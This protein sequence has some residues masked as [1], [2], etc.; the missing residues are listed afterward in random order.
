MG[1]REQQ[2]KGTEIKVLASLEDLYHRATG[3]R[4]VWDRAEW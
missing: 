3:Q 2:G 1:Q 4:R